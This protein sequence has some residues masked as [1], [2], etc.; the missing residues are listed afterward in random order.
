VTQ[1]APFTGFYAAEGYHQ[2][3]LDK[4]PND[5]YIVYNDLPKLKHLMQQFP[6]LLKS[7]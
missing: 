2:H 3:Y 6:E 5:P 4:N 1:V 7:R